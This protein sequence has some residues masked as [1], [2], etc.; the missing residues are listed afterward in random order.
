MA[1]V[2]TA[3]VWTIGAATL[4]TPVGQ[5][6]LGN[7]IFSGLQTENW[8]WVLFGCVASA[9]LALIVDQVLGLMEAGVAR[10]SRWRVLAGA[11]ALLAGAA[12]AGAV[13]LSLA[14]RPAYV[15]GAKNFTEQY[16]LAELI[17]QRLGE[18]GHRATQRSGLGSA[19]AFRALS[20]GDIDVYVD[21][22]GTIWTNV[23]GRR[24]QPPR[25][26]MLQEIDA[27]LRREHGVRLVGALGFE[28]AYA[29][30]MKRNHAAELGVASIADLAAHAPS[31]S[32]G[33][34]YEF[35]ARPEWRSLRDGYGLRFGG[36]RELQST[37]MYRAVAAGDVDV[38]TAFSSDGRIAGENLL[39]LDDPKAAIPPYDAIVMVS[40]KRANDPALLD[41]LTPL[42]GAISANLMRQANYLVDR[43]DDAL[44]PAAAARWLA[45]QLGAGS[46]GARP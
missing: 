17:G 2:R 14:Q 25:E 46:R 37:F 7:Y 12:L 1:G 39:V 36:R 23:M 27:W 6:S 8:T 42:V 22:S 3:A 24:D 35:F 29:L 34:D 31:L 18:G 11:A 26:Q 13:V 19:V 20:Q 32:I 43:P 15:V 4:S 10:R 16:I 41:A 30:A 9:V 5:T 38:I 45:A 44:R 28:N 33:S 21:Y 40:R